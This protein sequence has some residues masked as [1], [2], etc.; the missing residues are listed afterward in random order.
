MYSKNSQ[1]HTRTLLCPH[2]YPGRGD[3]CAALAWLCLS[4]V[5]FNRIFNTTFPVETAKIKFSR[6]FVTINCCCE[7]LKSV[8]VGY[9][10]LFLYVGI[11]FNKKYL[12]LYLRFLHLEEIRCNNSGFLRLTKIKIPLC[13]E[14]ML[15]WLSC[16]LWISYISHFSH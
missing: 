12:S 15:S 4:S 1:S 10:L 16:V 13:I 7:M 6:N 11:Y 9:Y 2:K 5:C 8:V 14:N 3:D